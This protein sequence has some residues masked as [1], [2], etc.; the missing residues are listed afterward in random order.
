MCTSKTYMKDVNNELSITYSSS[1]IQ[2]QVYL[3]SLSL[4]SFYYI[5]PHFPNIINPNR[6]C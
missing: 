2:L 3:E 1:K 4:A 6:K 5:F